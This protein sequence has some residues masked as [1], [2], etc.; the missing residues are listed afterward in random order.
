MNESDDLLGFLVEG[1]IAPQR[2]LVTRAFYQRV[3]G[4]PNSGPVNEAVLLTA[5]SRRVA[6]APRELREANVEFKQLLAGG[7][8]MEARI[9]ERV[10]LSNAGVVASF[11]DE[12]TRATSYLRASAQNNEQIVS[13]GRQI[14]DLMRKSLAQGELLFAE[15]REIKTELKL[16][17]ES[18]QKTAQATENNKAICLTIKE[19]VTHLADASSIHWMTIGVVI[20]SILAATA[21]LFSWWVAS[22]LLALA[23]GLLQ[24]MARTSWKFV[25]EKAETMKPLD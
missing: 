23:I 19:I 6:L 4:D 11:K 21:I 24:A 5:F 18:N 2:D 7:R 22:L 16:N 3:Q 13:E 25:R 1:L 12:A 9:R 14:A 15:L 8:E 10:E 20:G 17:R